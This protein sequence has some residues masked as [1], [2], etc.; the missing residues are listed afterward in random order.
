MEKPIL[1]LL[2]CRFWLNCASLRVV[3][4]IVLDVIILYQDVSGRKMGKIVRD[5]MQGKKGNS[6]KFKDKRG[7]RGFIWIYSE[8]FCFGE[9]EIILPSR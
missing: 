1:N 5:W 9:C 2:V 8:R 3:D 4:L 7:D 6:Y